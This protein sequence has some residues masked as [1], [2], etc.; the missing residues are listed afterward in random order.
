MNDIR[1][2]A[3]FDSGVGGISVLKELAA[4]MPEENYL[5]YGDSANAPYG[6][7]GVA[8]VRRLAVDCV[9]HLMAMGAKAVVIACNTAT[10]VAAEV[11]RETHKDV[12][13]IGVEP[14]LK[15]AVL[16]SKH[17]TV[18]VMG[19]PITL[20]EEKFRRLMESYTHQATILP[21]ACDRLAAMVEEGQ[22]SGDELLRYLEG[23]F[24]PYRHIQLDAVVLGC[25]HYP[26]VR[27]AIQ[28]VVGPSVCLFDGGLGTAKE[29]KR[30]LEEK[31]ALKADGKAGT[32]RFI[33]SKDSADERLFYERLFQ[34]E[35]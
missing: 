11:L 23:V 2:I 32:I 15:P 7:K 3:V 30:R 25:T 18:A 22:L 12:P 27:R 10:S 14:A 8:Q 29:T 34:S 21:I 17:P 9:E 20:Q 19:T 4:L 26:F 5:Y 6:S 24:A 33:S 16:S 1:P 31:N 28:T 35:I 13:I